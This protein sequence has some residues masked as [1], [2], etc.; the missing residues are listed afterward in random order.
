MSWWTGIEASPAETGAAI[1]LN[2]DFFAAKMTADELRALVLTWQA[3]GMSFE[4][5]HHNLSRGEVMRPGVSAEEE[6]HAIQAA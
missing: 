1:T 2:R 6:R 4:T 5:L 3:S